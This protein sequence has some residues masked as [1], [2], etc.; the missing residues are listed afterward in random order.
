MKLFS[1]LECLAN[2]T[3]RFSG[4]PP[5]RRDSSVHCHAQFHKMKAGNQNPGLHVC[6]DALQESPQPIQRTF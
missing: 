1:W 5:Q 4:L 2:K 6:M 3:K